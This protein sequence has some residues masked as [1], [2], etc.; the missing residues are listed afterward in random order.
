MNGMR[1]RLKPFPLLATVLLAVVVAGCGAASDVGATTDGGGSGAR[2]VVASGVS[3]LSTVTAGPSVVRESPASGAVEVPT[4]TNSSINVVT[5]T[6]VSATFSRPMDPATLSSVPAGSLATFTL[7][8]TNGG[9]VAGTVSMNAADTVATFAPSASALAPSTNYTAEVTMAARDAG[10]VALA[11]PF[12]WNFTTTAVPFTAQAPVNLGTAGTFA[13]L[14]KT[15]V[16]NV[17]ASAIN[18]NVGASPITGAAIGLTCPEVMTGIIYSV[19]AAG[20]A[21]KVTDA[22]FLTT[23]VGD[24]EIAYTD[25]AGRVFPDHVDLG[26]GEIGGLTLLPGLYKWNT[27]VSI[28]SDVTLAGGPDDVW[29]FQ[30]AGNISQA[31]AKNVTLTGG[32]LAKNVFWQSAGATA[33]G[34][35]AHFEGT[36][37]SKT[38]IA[39]KTGASTNGGLLAQSAVTLQ[40]NTVTVPTR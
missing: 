28:S 26:A 6:T 11:Q 13:L 31:G 40:K 36:I 15:G 2:I 18:G 32:A 37:L 12:T 39:M 7:K 38:M 34:T 24:M 25:A 30:I 14:A 21:C 35:T 9:T 23:V 5:G 22:N 8:A 20:P 27:G 33:I 17:Y 10:G 1:S 19:D 4:S 29:I 16:T 3:A